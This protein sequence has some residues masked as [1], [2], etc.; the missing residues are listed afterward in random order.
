MEGFVE[1]ATGLLCILSFV[2]GA[3]VGQKSVKNDEIKLPSINPVRIINEMNESKE[4]KKMMERNKI[5][6]ENIDNYDGTS[7]GQK[8]VPK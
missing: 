3:R 8:D 4:Q 5:I 1:I 2:I 6:A 7:L